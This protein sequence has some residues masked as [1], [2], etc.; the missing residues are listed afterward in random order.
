MKHIK[1]LE[2]VCALSELNEC[3]SGVNLQIY[4]YSVS[5]L[6]S[7]T[8]A[9]QLRYQCALKATTE[10]PQM[11]Y[12]T[13]LWIALVLLTNKGTKGNLTVGIG[14]EDRGICN[15]TQ[16]RSDCFLFSLR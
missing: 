9:S 7:H 12:Q 3:C 14:L 2:L 15:V 16:V 5:T 11:M 1:G 8:T 4:F 10:L 13:L 6:A